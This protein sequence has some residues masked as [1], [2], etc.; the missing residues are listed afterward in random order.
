MSLQTCVIQFAHAPFKVQLSCSRVCPVLHLS[1]P[2]Q[3]KISTLHECNVITW[4]D[5]HDHTHCSGFGE[6]C[7]ATFGKPSAPL[8]IG[9]QGLDMRN[10]HKKLHSHSFHR[11]RFIERQ[12]RRF[13]SWCSLTVHRFLLSLGRSRLTCVAIEITPKPWANGAIVRPSNIHACF[14]SS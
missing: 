11:L 14:I 8:T 13:R 9:G 10:G 5:I 3:T 2:I 1:S 7:R 6:K 12:D 4:R